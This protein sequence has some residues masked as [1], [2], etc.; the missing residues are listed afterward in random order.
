MKKKAKPKVKR[1]SIS[2]AQ[3]HSGVNIGPIPKGADRPKCGCC[4][5]P[6]PVRKQ[7]VQR[8][9]GTWDRDPNVWS[10]SGYTYF[11]S[12]TCALVFATKAMNKK[13]KQKSLRLKKLQHGS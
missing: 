13:M 2:D 4:D 7:W 5:K 10:Y 8:S 12:T 6:M 1:Q 9:N 11:C 3:M